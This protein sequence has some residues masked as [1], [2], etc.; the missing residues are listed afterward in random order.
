VLKKLCTFCGNG[1]CFV[2]DQNKLLGAINYG[3]QM[4]FLQYIEASVIAEH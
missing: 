1:Q 2:R 3:D 4:S